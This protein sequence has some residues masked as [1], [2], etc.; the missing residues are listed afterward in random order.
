LV[1]YGL[2]LFSR[3]IP[4]L[5]PDFVK[6]LL[7]YCF[8][9]VRRSGAVQWLMGRA[10]D[11]DHLKMLGVRDRSGAGSRQLE[12]EAQ[13]MLASM[14]LLLN[15]FGRPLVVFF[16]QLENLYDLDQIRKFQSMIFFLGDIR[17]AMLPVAFF[18]AQ[19][20]ELKFKE[21]FDDFCSGRFKANMFD[22]KGC[23]RDQALELIRSR[24]GLALKGVE[25]PNDM[26]PFYPDHKK[27]LTS[28][29]RAREMHPRQVINRANRLLHTI[30]W[31]APPE[32]RTPGQIL[33]EAF[34]TRYEEVLANID[35]YPPDVGRLVLALNLY[36]TNRPE[37]TPYRM[38]GVKPG[39]EKQKYI[40][41][42]GKVGRGK[43]GPVPV[44]FMIDVELHHR[45]V[46][47]SLRRGVAHLKNNPKGKAIYIRDTRCPFH[48]PDR[49]KEN[50]ALLQNLLMRGGHAIFLSVE[51][52]ARWYALARLKFDVEAGD[53]STDAGAA[54]TLDDL[55]EFIRSRA[56]G[57]KYP[58]FKIIDSYF[59]SRGGPRSNMR[60]EKK[61]PAVND[62]KKIAELAVAILKQSPTR[63]MKADLLARKISKEANMEMGVDR[64]ALTLGGHKRK[65][66]I[67][68]ARDGVI[69]SLKTE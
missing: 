46:A 9:H 26:H 8:F 7:Q 11:V 6:V 22:L 63:M 42:V 58:A 36:L 35:Q 66:N 21:Q 47:A 57:E 48:G 17:K 54:I 68:R 60:P 14:D 64:L 16:D 40:S 33:A 3:E 31:G 37:K 39:L 5:F 59:S 32:K 51:H 10:V 15:R 49:W 34:K 13:E 28:L 38:T 1:K 52:A 12:Q 62:S 2:R 50:N 67:F 24:L 65:F 56:D 19:D 69:L 29:L 25:T 18:R 61:K 23:N 45:A 4:E 44:V 41:L 43:Q 30:L 20:W 53:V 27:Q 55:K